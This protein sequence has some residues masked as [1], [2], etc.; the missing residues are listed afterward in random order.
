MNLDETI[1][2][3]TSDKWERR[4]FAEFAQTAIRYH[5]LTEWIHHL[6]MNPQDKESKY[7]LVFRRQASSMWVYAQTQLIRLLE[8]DEPIP[9]DLICYLY[10]SSHL[11]CSAEEIREMAYRNTGFRVY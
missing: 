2:D 11:F 1:E 8:T 6:E 5:N 10:G 3:M 9:A 7:L 4:L